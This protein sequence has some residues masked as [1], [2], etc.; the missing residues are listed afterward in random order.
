MGDKSKIEWRPVPG[1]AG[2]SVSSN[3]QII[4]PSGRPRKLQVSDT[5]HLYILYRFGGRNGRQKKLW[6]H[7]AVLEAFIGP[8]P[9]STSEGRHLDGN[10]KNNNRENLAWGARLENA[11]DRMQHGRYP[12]GEDHPAAVLTQEQAR[13]I[14]ASAGS[15][16]YVARRFGVSH[17]TILDIRRGNRWNR[18]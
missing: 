4:G 14:R 9:E 10:P 8:P 11:G 1:W 6:I 7:R 18:G 17:T 3:G 12:G 5:E 16:R 13:A 15:S 2:F